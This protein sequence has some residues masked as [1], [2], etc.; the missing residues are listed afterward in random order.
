MKRAG[1]VPG[2]PYKKSAT[3]VGDVLAS[4]I[5]YGD[6]ALYDTL[7]PHGPQDFSLRSTLVDGQGNV[8]VGIDRRLRRAYR[9][10]S[11]RH[12]RRLTMLGGQ[13]TRTLSPFVPTSM[14][15]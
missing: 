4:T 11:A 8:R 2:R 3:V 15:G 7:V 13:S 5:P 9:Y 1:L 10:R 6:V 14:T 12:T